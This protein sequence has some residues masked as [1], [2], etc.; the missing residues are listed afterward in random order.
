[1]VALIVWKKREIT[2]VS[3]H[4]NIKNEDIEAF[5]KA[6]GQGT[7][8]TGILVF[9]MGIFWAI[10]FIPMGIIVFAI[11]FIVLFTIYFKAQK[12]YNGR[13]P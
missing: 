3:M 7:I 12:K 4:S 1:M 13:E 9:C 11:C 5:T 10:D 6:I 2:W 8:G